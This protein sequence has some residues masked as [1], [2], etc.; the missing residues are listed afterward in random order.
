MRRGYPLARIRE[1]AAAAAAHTRNSWNLGLT[2]RT[3]ELTRRRSYS[4]R[5]VRTRKRGSRCDICV[6]FCL[7]WGRSGCGYTTTS[8]LHSSGWKTTTCLPSPIVVIVIVA[9]VAPR[10]HG[11]DLRLISLVLTSN[12]GEKAG[13]VVAARVWGRVATRKGLSSMSDGAENMR[14]AF[15]R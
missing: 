13:L 7:N 14:L 6:C 5:I 10:R 9:V 3:R 2:Q 1:A 12:V 11:D 4:A 15:R 8:R